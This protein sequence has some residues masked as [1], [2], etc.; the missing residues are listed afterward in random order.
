MQNV[1]NN[2]AGGLTTEWVD[3]GTTDGG[4]ASKNITIESD[5]DYEIH[6]INAV[7]E[8]SDVK[9]TNWTGL[10][11]IKDNNGNQLFNEP[12]PL[13]SIAGDSRQPGRQLPEI[14]FRAGRTITV[15]L[16][17]SGTTQTYVQVTFLGN[18]V[19]PRKG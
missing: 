9:V 13:D 1:E 6:T 5:S 4:T 3:L 18:R 7:V 11:Q 10:I 2:L 12:V 15:E 8:Q 19:T 14:V 17:Q 16:T